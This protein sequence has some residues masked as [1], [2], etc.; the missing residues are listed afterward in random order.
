M[1]RTN[2]Q[3]DVFDLGS[4]SEEDEEDAFLPDRPMDDSSN[5]YIDQ[6]MDNP[7]SH[8]DPPVSDI[9]MKDNLDN[10]HNQIDF[11]A[12]SKCQQV[13]YIVDAARRA[14]FPS[15][16]DAFIAQLRNFI[17]VQEDGLSVV[18]SAM[19]KPELRSI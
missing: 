13:T 10:E 7:P 5:E 1:P 19:Y 14:V 17:R 6:F 3:P 11:R 4:Q 18:C 16:A 9:P 12:L 15:L 2:R 8:S